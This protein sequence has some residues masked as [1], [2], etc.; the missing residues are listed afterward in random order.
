MREP[1]WYWTDLIWA[2]TIPRGNKS[3]SH[4]CARLFYG[5]PGSFIFPRYDFCFFLFALLR[6]LNVLRDFWMMFASGCLSVK[7]RNSIRRIWCALGTCLGS[8]VRLQVAI[9]Y[10]SW[11]Q[12]A[13]ISSRNV[14][15]PSLELQIEVC[16][17]QT[18]TRL[19]IC[20][21]LS[22]TPLV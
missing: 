2:I 16:S 22:L 19:H 14:S 20:T 17:N 6:W 9:P 11:T 10:L 15:T 3:P 21:F 7:V 8:N 18:T 13:Q 1:D 4:Y 12:S 5:S